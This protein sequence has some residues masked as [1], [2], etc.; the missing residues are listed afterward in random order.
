MKFLIFSIFYPRQ[1][2]NVVLLE[3]PKVSDIAGRHTSFIL[4]CIASV[5]VVGEQRK[6]K[7]RNRNGI[8]PARNWGESQNNSLPLNPTETLATL[9]SF[10]LLLQLV[11]GKTCLVCKFVTAKLPVV[12]PVSYRPS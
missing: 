7:E 5:S 6:A 3:K 9:A 2:I 10:I 12:S 4:V 1:N 8:L 11:L